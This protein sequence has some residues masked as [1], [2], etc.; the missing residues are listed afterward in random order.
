VI[1]FD[2]G[3]GS[4]PPHLPAMLLVCVLG[5]VLLLDHLG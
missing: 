5:L 1:Q 2:G 4:E 3:D